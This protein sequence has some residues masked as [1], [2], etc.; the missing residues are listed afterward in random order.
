MSSSDS[1]QP[2]RSPPPEYG[3]ESCY[4]TY[5]TPDPP[6]NC[7]RCG[8]GNIVRLLPVDWTWECPSCSES[9]SGTYPDECPACGEETIARP[10][11]GE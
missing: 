1:E 3:C 8:G 2:D 5:T 11:A 10:P 6:S 4:E 9:G 7:E